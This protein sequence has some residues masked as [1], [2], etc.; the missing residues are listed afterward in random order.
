[1]YAGDSAGGGLALSYALSQ[2]DQHTTPTAAALL[3]FSP[4]VD[5]TMTNPHIASVEPHD[6]ML[7]S[8]NLQKMRNLV[9]RTPRHHRSRR[10]PH[11][12]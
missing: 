5:A 4:W 9:G 2:R 7:N 11:L 8:R 10:Q 6:I 3:L 12:R 1:V